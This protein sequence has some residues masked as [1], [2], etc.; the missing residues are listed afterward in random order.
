[1]THCITVIRWRLVRL[2]DTCLDRVKVTQWYESPPVSPSIT[3]IF[4]KNSNFHKNDQNWS[5]VSGTNKVDSG[6]KNLRFM[7]IKNLIFIFRATWN[8]C[9]MYFDDLRYFGQGSPKRQRTTIRS[10]LFWPN[11]WL[12]RLDFTPTQIKIIH[13][14]RMR[15]PDGHFVRIPH[16][17]VQ[18]RR[19]LKKRVPL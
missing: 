17:E 1:M 5:S 19:P 7:A 8:C 18:R 4:I 2:R 9:Q 13:L 14:S 15:L 12:W 16:G 11:L 3:I 10:K 6:Q